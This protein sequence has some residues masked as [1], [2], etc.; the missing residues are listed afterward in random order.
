MISGYLILTSVPRQQH[1]D[2]AHDIEHIDLNAPEDEIR[3]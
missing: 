3:S 1:Y 2:V